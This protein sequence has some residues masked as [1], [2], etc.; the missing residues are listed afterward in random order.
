[1]RKILSGFPIGFLLLVALVIY[2]EISI[3]PDFCR[4][5]NRKLSDQEFIEIAVTYELNQGNL[6]LSESEKTANDFISNHPNCCKVLRSSKKSIYSKIVASNTQEMD[7][8]ISIHMNY[9]ANEF[10]STSQG[11]ISF[12]RYIEEYLDTNS[13]GQVIKANRIGI[14]SLEDKHIKK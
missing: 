5:E 2:F 1:M 9:E 14:I 6:K 7:F 8:D 10:N 4:S 12:H 3:P 11:R 13:C